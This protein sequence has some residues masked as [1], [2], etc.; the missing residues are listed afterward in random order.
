MHL[1]ALLQA[2]GVALAAAVSNGALIGPAQVGARIVEM[3]NKG[4]NHSLWTLTVAMALVVLGLAILAAGVP[5]V[6]PALVL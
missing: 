4:R 6:G 1:I 2:R 3:A 5:A